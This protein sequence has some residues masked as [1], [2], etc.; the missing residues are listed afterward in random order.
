MQWGFKNLDSLCGPT[1][2][3]VFITVKPLW[4]DSSRC[5]IPR[6][7][8]AQECSHGYMGDAPGFL[9]CGSADETSKNCS[10]LVWAVSFCEVKW[11][12]LEATG[13]NY[14]M[15]CTY[16]RFRDLW[17]SVTVIKKQYFIESSIFLLL[18]QAECWRSPNQDRAGKWR[19][20]L[21]QIV[22]YQM[23]N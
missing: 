9:I 20:A 16:P 19:W 8:G 1:T 7:A 17:V 11:E 13:L 6:A 3:S 21:F 5:S 18:L 22:H 15:F 2:A 12:F 10:K 4:K 14:L 23:N